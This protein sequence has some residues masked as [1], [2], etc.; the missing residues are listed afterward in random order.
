VS[1]GRLQ[2]F[3]SR[4]ESR[5]VGG[6]IPSYTTHAIHIMKQLNT[7]V[8]SCESNKVL[9]ML[10]RH[11]TLPVPSP[12][13]RQTEP[14]TNLKILKQARG[15]AWSCLLLQDVWRRKCKSFQF[16]SKQW[17]WKLNVSFFVVHCCCRCTQLP[18]RFAAFVLSFSFFD[19]N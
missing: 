7:P 15:I 3:C 12:S 11:F 17:G 1:D 6:T 13:A 4:Q 14:E 19:T 8:R 10:C 16:A 18:L 9:R 2:Q 5:K